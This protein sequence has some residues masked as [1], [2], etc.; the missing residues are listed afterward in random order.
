MELENDAFQIIIEEE[1]N[2]TQK[3]LPGDLFSLT[4][5]VDQRETE[6]SMIDK[7][8]INDKMKQRCRKKEN[9]CSFKFNNKFFYK[10]DQ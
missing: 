6:F 8:A 7:Q 1:S 9:T 2:R 10:P 4:T 5:I 3:L